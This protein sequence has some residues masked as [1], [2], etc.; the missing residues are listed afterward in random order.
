MFDS[1]VASTGG[2]EFYKK[3]LIDLD[4]SALKS[5]TMKKTFDNLARLR[6]MRTRNTSAAIG[7]SPPRW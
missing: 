7:T 4:E 2:I 1:V 3:V 6:A 5:D